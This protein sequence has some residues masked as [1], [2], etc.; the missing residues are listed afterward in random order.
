M[1]ARCQRPGCIERIDFALRNGRGG[2]VRRFN[3]NK[4]VNDRFI[5]RKPVKIQRQLAATRNGDDL[6]HLAHRRGARCGLHICRWRFV[7]MHMAFMGRNRR[8]G[9]DNK[10]YRQQ[11]PKKGGHVAPQK[12]TIV[13]APHP[14]RGIADGSDE[15][16]WRTAQAFE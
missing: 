10:Q 3:I 9:K 2:P 8:G 15:V 6:E 4:R 5:R 16:S 14:W 11:R 7:A 1:R 13:V 12:N